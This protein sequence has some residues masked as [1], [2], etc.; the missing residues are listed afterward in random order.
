MKFKV[1][2][3]NARPELIQF[4][5]T[6]NTMARELYNRLND[7]FIIDVEFVLQTEAET[8]IRKEY[9]LRK[10]FNLLSDERH[11]IYFNITG[12]TVVDVKPTKPLNSAGS[13]TSGGQDKFGG[14]DDSSCDEDSPLLPDGQSDDQSDDQSDEQSDEQSESE[15]NRSD[16]FNAVKEGIIYMLHISVAVSLC[17]IAYKI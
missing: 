12:Q 5:V 14:F 10:Y 3:L 9:P 6:Y 8:I 15:S 4:R 1:I 17:V 13:N 7:I 16:L 11:D 2:G